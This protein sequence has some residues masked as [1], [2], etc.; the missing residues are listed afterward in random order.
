MFRTSSAGFY[1]FKIKIF[2]NGNY[3]PIIKYL[4]E[5]HIKSPR[6]IIQMSLILGIYSK[7]GKLHKKDYNDVLKDFSLEGK[8]KAFTKISNNFLFSSVCGSRINLLQNKSKDILV[9]FSGNI[10]GYNTELKKLRSKGHKFIHKSNPAEFLLHSYEEYGLSFLRKINGNFAFAV[11][12]IKKEKL[13]IANDFFGFYPLFIFQ[14]KN[15]IIFCTEYQPILKYPGFKNCLDYNSVSEYFSLGFVISDKTFFKDIKNL[16][17]GS[18]M[19]F[20]R[21]TSLKERYFEEHIKERNGKSLD[22]CCKNVSAH[23][24]RAIINRINPSKEVVCDLSGGADTRLI[25]SILPKKLRESINFRTSDRGLFR[26]RNLNQDIFIAK[27]IS[28]KLDLKHEIFRSNQIEIFDK[29]YYD[30]LR[31]RKIGKE[32]HLCGL[33]GGEI[34]GG[35]LYH[36]FPLNLETIQKEEI[37]QKIN[38]IFTENFIK[39]IN[40]PYD[41]LKEEIKN[42]KA[43]NKNLLF[44]IN[45]CTRSFFTSIYGNYSGGFTTPYQFLIRKDTPFLDKNFIKAILS[46]PKK[47]LKNYNLYNYLYKTIYPE[48]TSIPTNNEPLSKKKGSCMVYLNN[49]INPKSMLKPRYS[50]KL[51]LLLFKPRLFSLKI[52]SQKKFYKSLKIRETLSISIASYLDQLLSLLSSSDSLKNLKL[53]YS[54]LKKK[55][56]LLPK[57][58]YK[59]FF[60][61]RFKFRSLLDKKS[62]LVYQFIEFGTWLDSYFYKK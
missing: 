9:L 22:H 15:R 45:V 60:S 51:F 58:F 11:Y 46:V 35:D 54:S 49:Y 27:K 47:Y 2:K 21:E 7:D 25:V 1:D 24:R 37:T 61:K 17:P 50:K 34:L 26:Y 8:R 3:F 5:K 38:S 59:F 43:D 28:E 6:L 13:I 44:M 56:I 40:H 16:S 48:L 19:I 42:T 36:M 39:K 53:F 14:D 41:T 29:N 4:I 32:K 20:S 10:Y 31:I 55:R 52:F 12:D 33:H 57:K 62:I 18:Y 30:Q 23:L